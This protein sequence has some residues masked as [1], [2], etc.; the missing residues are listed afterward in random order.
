MTGNHL[1]AIRDRMKLTQ[2]ELAVRLKITPSSVARMEQ[3]VMIVTPP[4]ELLIS[5]VAREAGVDLA[6]G[7]T[8]RRAATDKAPHGG[9]AR[10]SSRKG[11]RRPRS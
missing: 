5:F 9:K 11:G 10:D 1:R 3:G 6:H 2:A 4:M 7:Q 8:S